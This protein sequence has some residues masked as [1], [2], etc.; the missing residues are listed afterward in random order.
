MSAIAILHGSRWGCTAL[1]GSGLEPWTAPHT[2]E[3]GHCTTTPSSI[4][5]LHGSCMW[6]KF[7]L[8]TQQ[9]ALAR[10]RIRADVTSEFVF[11]RKQLP[12][13]ELAS[14]TLPISNSG[15]RLL[16]ATKNHIKQ[17][18]LKLLDF[19]QIWPML[20]PHQV[21]LGASLKDQVC[22]HI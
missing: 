9:L 2:R 18:Q 1:L 21:Y 17:G 15:L 5:M 10:L 11:N 14:S 19:E 3:H 12:Q 20:P 13:M 6:A 16:W 4:S 7:L 8:H 22:S